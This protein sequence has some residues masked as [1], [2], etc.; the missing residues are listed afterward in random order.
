MISGVLLWT[1]TVVL[2]LAS[3]LAVVKVPFGALQ[4]LA[5]PRLQFFCIAAGLALLFLVVPV[6]KGNLGALIAVGVAAVQAAY[7]APFTPLWGRQS[8]QADSEMVAQTDCQISLMAANVKLSNRAY[9]RLIELVHREAPDVL[10]AIEVDADWIAV[11]KDALS[12]DY[13]HTIEVALDT[14]YGLCVLSRLPLEDAQVRDL[15]TQG[16][17]S[18]R[19]KV[20]LRDGQAVRLYVVHPEPPVINHDT[21]GRDSEIAMIGL[22]AAEDP[23]PAIVAGVLQHL[24]CHASLDALAVGSSVS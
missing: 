12:A 19:T 21:V 3:L 22:E 18:I 6:W 4:G 9:H 15:I 24:Q 8:R 5:F 14:G 20:T 7:I 13:P 2:V 1:V 16:V 10:M 23:L 11:L 17:P